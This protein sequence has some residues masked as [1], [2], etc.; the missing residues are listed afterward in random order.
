M[1]I[2]FCE[3]YRS[4][5]VNEILDHKNIIKTFKNLISQKK[6]INSIFF[7]QPGTGK[8][9][10]IT[11]CAKE[12]YGDKFKVMVLELNGS[13]D[14]GIGTI[15]NI[16]SDFAE[17][18]QIFSKGSKLII[19]DEA[20]S[21]TYDA[22]FALKRIMENYSKTTKFCLVCNYIYKIIPHLQSRCFI[23]RFPN[24][25][26]KFIKEKLMFISKKEKI[27]YTS[28][29]LNV[30]INIS[31]GDMRKS[32]NLLHSLSLTTT[33]I[34]KDNIYKYTGYILDGTIDEL[35]D[36]LIHLEFKEAFYK[37]KKIIK[38]N[39]ICFIDFI[40]NIYKF[41]DKLNLN[42]KQISEFINN[43]A[44]IEYNLLNNASFDIQLGALIAS[45]FKLRY[46][47]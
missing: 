6:F 4:T 1:N 33:I 17:Y 34:N 20:D 39:K 7:G 25:T 30:L 35:I 29:G 2:P 32:I 31:E 5:S 38:K 40:S 14:R 3:K 18:N 15:R 27:N 19:L 47:K 21:M 23:F 46:I 10:L 44:E 8:T 9:S 26:P 42:N 12:I 28:E 41:I 22:Q 43:I 36:I 16:I 13:D 11:S 37:I 24:I 45:F